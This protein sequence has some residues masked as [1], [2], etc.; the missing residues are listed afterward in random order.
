MLKI[1]SIC[2]LYVHV[3]IDYTMPGEIRCHMRKW[4]WG[5]QTE[6]LNQSLVMISLFKASGFVSWLNYGSGT[7]APQAQWQ[8]YVLMINSVTGPKG[9]AEVSGGGSPAWHRFFC[10]LQDSC[11]CL[12]RLDLWSFKWQEVVMVGGWHEGKAEAPGTIYRKRKL[13]IC[14]HLLQLARGWE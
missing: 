9:L 13:N 4:Q 8:V 12:G 14:T 11:Q 6:S 2:L 3:Y 5:D 1:V 10:V 7:V